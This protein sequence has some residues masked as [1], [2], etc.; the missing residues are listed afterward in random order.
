[1]TLDDFN[2]APR[3]V[4]SDMLLACAAIPAWADAIIA[5]RP[6]AGRDRLIGLAGDLAL[7]WRPEQVAGALVHHPRI[8][9]RP[10]GGDVQSRH[11]RREQAAV[12]PADATLAAE[13]LAGNRRYER[14]FGQVFL[15]RAAGRS[16]HEILAL[17]QRRLTH[18]RAQEQRE[19]AMQLRE[20]ALLRLQ[21]GISQ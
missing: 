21:E 18:S 19:T 6:F 8:G 17:L 7:G 13:L 9:E 15:V 2:L 14:R 5:A 1:M 16:G 10:G 12:D 3:Q 20:I 4:V 11:S